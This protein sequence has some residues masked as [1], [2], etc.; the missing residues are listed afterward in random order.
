M[1]SEAQRSTGLLIR[2]ALSAVLFIV[3]AASAKGESPVDVTR[4]R[5]ILGFEEQEL[6][7][8]DEV[9]REEKPGRESWFYL[10]EQPEGFDFAARFQAGEI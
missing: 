2:R 4:E 6:S 3:A 8:S 9:S 1:H 5:I 7:Q 10:L